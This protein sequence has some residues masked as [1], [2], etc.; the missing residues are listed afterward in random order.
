MSSFI[1]EII[2][3]DL[4]AVGIQVAIV[5]CNNVMCPDNMDFRTFK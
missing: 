5:T 1:G 3:N 4:V 2:V